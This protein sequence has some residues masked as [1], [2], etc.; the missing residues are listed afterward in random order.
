[1]KNLV[2]CL[3]GLIRYFKRLKTGR[4]LGCTKAL[5]GILL[6]DKVGPMNIDYF[7]LC[8]FTRDRSVEINP[9]RL[10]TEAECSHVEYWVFCKI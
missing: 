9:R 3:P 7:H 10:L 2:S 6:P 5:G 1:M 4:G 8:M